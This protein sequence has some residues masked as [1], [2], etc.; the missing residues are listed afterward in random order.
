MFKVIKKLFTNK[1][2]YVNSEGERNNFNPCTYCGKELGKERF[3]YHKGMHFHRRCIRKWYLNGEK[4]IS[5]E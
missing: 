1:K 4:G 3:S 5:N 2:S